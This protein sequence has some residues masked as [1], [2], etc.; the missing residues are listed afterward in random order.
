M[1]EEGE[2]KG[3]KRSL[4]QRR[5]SFDGWVNGRGRISGRDRNGFGDG[6]GDGKGGGGVV[7]EWESGWI[8][9][10]SES[11]SGES[12]LTGDSGGL[13]GLGVWVFT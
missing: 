3:K 8:V 7:G 6:D 13:G 10:K 5:L 2:G 9:V 11:E 1:I 4:Q 12:L